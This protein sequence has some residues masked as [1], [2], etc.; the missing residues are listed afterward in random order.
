VSELH[1][2]AELAA[3]GPSTPGKAILAAIVDI[4]ASPPDIR[5]GR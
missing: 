4:V 1:G 5:S 3:I 2:T